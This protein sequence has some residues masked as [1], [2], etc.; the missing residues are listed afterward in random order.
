[1][2]RSVIALSLLLLGLVSSGAVCRSSGTQ[3]DPMVIKYWTV[4][5]E[6][7]NIKAVV[8]AF[9][10]TH[11]YISFEIKQFQP[12]EYEGQL[13]QAWAEGR[14]PDIFSLPNS[15]IG[16]FQELIAPL[17]ASTTVTAVTTKTT[18]GRKE[19]VVT[20]ETKASTSAREISALF[21][22]AVYDDVIKVNQSAKEGQ[23]KEQV[24]GLPLSFDT[25]VLY[26]NKDLLDQANIPVPAT[27]WDDFVKQVPA[28]TLVDVNDNI[29]QAGAALGTSENVPR[30][31]D[32]VSLLM[33]QNGAVMTEGSNV[34]FDREIDLAGQ[35]FLPG[36]Q[37]VEF[38]TSF[39]TPTVEWYSWNAEQEDA[40]ESFIAGK[41]AYFIGYHYHLADI[42]ARGDQ[43]N[44]DLAP[45]PQ[46]DLTAAVNYPNYW[47]ETV[48]VNSL[49]VDEAW[50]F[51]E[52]LTTNETNV[53][54]ILEVTEEPAALRN[55]IEKQKEDFV[56]AIFANQSLTAQSWYAGTDP[57]A[58]EDEFA[59][60]ITIINEGRLDTLTAVENTADKIELT[61]ETK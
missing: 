22:Q 30:F 28:L 55:L 41:T 36:V 47:V 18:L 20:D 16:A 17:P 26:Y 5:N 49:Y 39:A 12:D 58:A 25:L 23:P 59:D 60:M 52:E 45:I 61:Y 7:E 31:F 48:S 1:M 9:T 13:I 4:F 35:Q 32:I 10:A 27:T 38:Y 8:D 2:K 19:T 3:P 6:E 34:Q 15:H 29:I 21:P 11:P 57:E 51:I 24:Y 42:Q 14:G 46:V 37:A 40:L 43:L 54:A 50:A 33:M 53:A 56:L 44:F